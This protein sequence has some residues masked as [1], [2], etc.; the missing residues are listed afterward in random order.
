[1]APE[2][3]QSVYSYILIRGWLSHVEWLLSKLTHHISSN[4]FI[5]L[6]SSFFDPSLSI[7]ICK[8]LEP[9][10]HLVQYQYQSMSIQSGFSP[11]D[12]NPSISIHTCSTYS[13]S[14]YKCQFH[15][16]IY[17]FTHT[18]IYIYIH[19]C[20]HLDI[21]LHITTYTY[22]HTHAN[23]FHR[24]HP[25]NTC[26]LST[27]ICYHRDFSNRFDFIGICLRLPHSICSR[28]AI[29]LST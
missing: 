12:A 18:H 20:V 4:Q 22:T 7:Y 27:S 17:I 21:S 23:N 26:T 10:F 9:Y 3:K 15:I 16:Y 19:M 2:T 14:I 6:E 8:D 5:H 25:I 29:F 1:M 11:I 24:S 13:L 28:M